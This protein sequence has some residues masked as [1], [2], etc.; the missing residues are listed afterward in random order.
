[1]HIQFF[2]PHIMLSQLYNISITQVSS[3]LVLYIPT[4][5]DFYHASLNDACFLRQPTNYLP[6]IFRDNHTRSGSINNNNDEVT[7]TLVSEDMGD[8]KLSSSA[9][10]QC[11]QLT[12]SSVHRLHSGSELDATCLVNEIGCTDV[13]STATNGHKRRN[14]QIHNGHISKLCMSPPVNNC[15]IKL[16]RPPQPPSQTKAVSQNKEVSQNKAVAQTKVFSPPTPSCPQLNKAAKISPSS[17]EGR[18]TTLH[19]TNGVTSCGQSTPPS[20]LSGFNSSGDSTKWRKSESGSRC[21]SVSSASSQSCADDQRRNNSWPSLA[22][23]NR[24]RSSS[25]TSSLVSLSSRDGGSAPGATKASTLTTCK[26]SNCVKDLEASEL[27]DHLHNV[28]VRSQEGESFVCLWANC[29]VYD[30]SSS[31][32][33]WLERHVLFHSG[34]KP[35]KCIVDKCGQQFPSQ[36]GLERHVNGH[37]RHGPK[38]GRHKE[39][40]PSKN[41]KKKAKR[42]RPLPGLYLRYFSFIVLT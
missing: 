9:N 40:T 21:S 20:V 39:D 22:L 1:M 34:D 41:K 29:K 32:R 27:N 42:K 28:H 36:Y 37:F 5:H 30:K 15:R 6:F 31:S 23:N 18:L 12:K 33:K 4:G 25:S 35:F 17:P 11:V 3:H 38:P 19:R 14:G 16:V 2:N 10:D 13:R 26:W 7:S 8:T 24:E